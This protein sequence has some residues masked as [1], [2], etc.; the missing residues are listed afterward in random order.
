MNY[1]QGI[2]PSSGSDFDIDGLLGN[3]LKSDD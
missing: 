2:K 3:L 1:M